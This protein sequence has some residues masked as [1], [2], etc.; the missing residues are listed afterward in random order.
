MSYSLN[1]VMAAILGGIQD[2]LYYIFKTI[3]D[4]AQ[5]IATVV[6]VSVMGYG[7]MKFGT[8]LLRSV[9]GFVRGLF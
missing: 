2:T 8:G 6:V 1:D 5:T 7:I 3:A 4:N 9:T